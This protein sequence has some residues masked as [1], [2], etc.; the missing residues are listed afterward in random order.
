M[1]HETQKK[2]EHNH[3]TGVN[4][5]DYIVQ[6]SAFYFIFDKNDKLVNILPF[7]SSMDKVKEEI[8]NIL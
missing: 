6:H 7:G 4:S 2:Y 8:K 5:D 1:N 3:E